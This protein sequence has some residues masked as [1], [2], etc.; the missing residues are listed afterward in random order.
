MIFMTPKIFPHVA[1]IGPGPVG[2][3][4]A[5]KLSAV[6]KVSLLVKSPQKE[7]LQNKTL[8]IHGDL[9]AKAAP[10][11]IRILPFDSNTEFPDG[12]VIAICV[13]AYDLD[14]VLKTL[15]PSLNPHKTLLLFSNGLGIFLQA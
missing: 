14:D 15:S 7:A 13:K 10:G 3:F 1:V 12:T 5:V 9:S 4:L 2:I 8:E 6:C 11:V